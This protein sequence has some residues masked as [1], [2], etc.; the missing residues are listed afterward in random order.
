VNLEF[1]RLRLHFRAVEPVRFPPGKAGNMLRGAFGTALRRAACVPECSNAATC[2]LRATCAYS[3]L[4]EPR[5]AARG[6]GPSGLL[7]WPRPF[8]FRARHLDGQRFEAGQLFHFDVHLFDVANPGFAAFA[9]SFARLAQD[10]MGPGRGRTELLH[11]AF[12]GL[13]GAPSPQP[14]ALPLARGGENVSRILVRFVTPTELKGAPQA[15]PNF[16]TLFGRIRDRVSNLRA[17]Y[18][19]GPLPI[20]F[21]GMGARAER[22][23]MPRCELRWEQIQRRSS[24]TRQSHPLG[25]FVGEAE[26]EGD[27]AEFLPYLDAAKWTGVGRQTVWGKGEIETRVVATS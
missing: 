11:A 7:D 3:R 22:V 12:I 14:I 21:H 18:G 15:H 2:A 8:V 1:F 4:F 19:P 9:A 5:A 27:L 24:R 20:D 6:T 26:Y 25:G 17:L 10:G 16:A 23:E 13:D